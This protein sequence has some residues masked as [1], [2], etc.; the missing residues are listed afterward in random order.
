METKNITVRV[1]VDIYDTMQKNVENPRMDDAC[2]INQQIVDSVRKLAAIQRRSLQELRGKFTPQEWAAMADMLN[3][4]RVTEDFRYYADALVAEIE[5]SDHYEGIGAKW[6]IDIP[7]L[8]EKARQLTA[9][10]LDALYL[11]VETWWQTCKVDTDI[12]EWGK[13]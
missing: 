4:T 9:A 11:R 13:F 12:L 5:D 7:A 8:C 3:S 1:P 6:E 10:Q 2:S